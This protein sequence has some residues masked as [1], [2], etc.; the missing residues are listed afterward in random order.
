MIIHFILFN[1][2]SL[3]LFPKVNTS[4]LFISPAVSTSALR[5]LRAE[6]S[7]E[8]CIEPRRMKGM[9]SHL[10]QTRKPL[11]QIALWRFWAVKANVTSPPSLALAWIVNLN[12]GA[13][14]RHTLLNTQLP[15]GADRLEVARVGFW[16]SNTSVNT[17]GVRHS[18]ARK[19]SESY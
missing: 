8:G 12:S 9:T 4:L 5:L 19:C 3:F 17:G 7:R 13:P 2:Q 6:W 1:L 16:P 18:N 15:S 14:R 11:I 10:S